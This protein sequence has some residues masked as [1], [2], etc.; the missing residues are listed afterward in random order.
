[1]T[2]DRRETPANGRVAA[3]HLAGRVAAERFVQPVLHRVT[4]P[5]TDLLRAPGGAR[6]RQLVLGEGVE[7]LEVHDGH[8]F[9]WAVRDGYVGYVRAE[10]LCEATAAPTHMV[11]VPATHA[12]TAPDLKRPEICGLSFGSRLCVV[13]Q[14][15]AFVETAEGWF[16]PEPHLRPPDAPFSDPVSVADLFLGAPYLWGGN[17]IWGIDCSGLVQAAFLACGHPC[18]GDSDQ[19]ARALGAALP[20][21]SPPRRGDLLFWRGHVALVAG[22]GMLIHANAR[23]MSVAREPLDEAIARIA[24]AGEGPVL[25]HRRV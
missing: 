1:M 4:R 10:A 6:D 18:P 7:V 9:G 22:P 14:H 13:A 23:S 17:S 21:G 2:G 16:V 8:A 24:A 5:L 25:A 15:G 12:Y 20:A 11:A 19:Q 3:R